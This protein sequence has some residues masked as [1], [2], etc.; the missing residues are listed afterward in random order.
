MSLFKTAVPVDIEAIK[1]LLPKEH[2]IDAVKFDPTTN[3]VELHWHA[4]YVQTPHTFATEWPL[5]L[6]QARKLPPTA[7]EVDRDAI[8]KA[9]EAA[10]KADQKL[11][12]VPQPKPVVPPITPAAHTPKPKRVKPQKTTKDNKVVDNPVANSDKKL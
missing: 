5:A 8:L 4:R 10:L 12:A 1:K 9:K 11:K 2:S 7:K 3:A 6:L